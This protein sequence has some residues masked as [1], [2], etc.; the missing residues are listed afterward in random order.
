M[1]DVDLIPIELFHIIV[2][3]DLHC[4]VHKFTIPTLILNTHAFVVH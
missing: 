1:V 4:N 3:I 2:T